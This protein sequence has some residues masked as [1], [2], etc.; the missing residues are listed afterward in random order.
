MPPFRLVCPVHFVRMAAWDEV[1]VRAVD[2]LVQWR[3][4]IAGLHVDGS[5]APVERA[6]VLGRI[7]AE[8]EG[9]LEAAVQPVVE[10]V[11]D[12]SARLAVFHPQATELVVP[13]KV[14]ITQD[15]TLDQCLLRMG[16]VA[17][18]SNGEARA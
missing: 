14:W 9:L 3:L 6:A 17:A 4:R 2:S 1:I 11:L 10:M 12:H 7:K 18:W 13:A 5:L 8:A 16:L 15:V